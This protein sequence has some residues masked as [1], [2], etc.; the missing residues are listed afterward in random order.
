VTIS[1]CATTRAGNPAPVT[2][3][4]VTKYERLKLP[5]DMPTTCPKAI[6]RAV[7]LVT[8]GT[9]YA[10]WEADRFTLTRC[11]RRLADVVAY[12]TGTAPTP[13]PGPAPA[14]SA[15]RNG[16]GPVQEPAKDAQTGPRP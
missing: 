8:V 12:L 1:S 5:K 7:A 15:A 13:A 4:V 10:A 14:S 3:V 9:L 16:L 2:P 6:P 11:A